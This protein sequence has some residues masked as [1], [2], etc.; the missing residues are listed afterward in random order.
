MITTSPTLYIKGTFNGWGLD[1]PLSEA[2]TGQFSTTICLSSDTH[3]FKITDQDGTALWTFS[4]HPID[5]TL[6]VVNKETPLVNTQG[7][8]NDLHFK[9]Q[10]TGRFDVVVTF[11]GQHATVA[12]SASKENIEPT[13]LRDHLTYQV[14]AVHY[15]PRQPPAPVHNCLA[16]DQLFAQI[17][18]SKSSPFPFV[19]GDNQDG[20]YEGKTHTFANAGKYRHSQGWY[21]GTFASFIDGKINDKTKALD[22]RLQAYG[23]EHRYES[24]TD[25]F[26]LISGQR[27]ACLSVQSHQ[28]KALSIVPELN[29]AFNQSEISTFKHGIVY[30]LPAS[31]CPDGAP[32]HIA[33]TANKPCTFNEVSFSDHPELDSTLHLSGDNVK[34]FI[35]SL[36]NETQFD[37]YLCFAESKS[38]AIH[39]AKQAID[40]DLV[41]LNRY[42]IY[43]F[44]CKN[45]L[46]TNDIEYNRAVMWARL[47]SRTFVNHEFGAGIWAGLPWFK[48]CWGRDTF[49]AL[50]GTSLINGQFSE[51]KEIITNFA[52][53]QMTDEN[54]INYGRVPNRVTSLTNMIYNTTD[55]TPWMIREVMEYLNYSGDLT[56]AQEI[57]PV[58]KRFVEGIEKRYLDENGLM[59]HRDPDTWMDAKIDG[60]IPWSARGNRANDIQALWYASLQ[61]AIVLAELN[62][63]V[64]AKTHWASL[65][66]QVRSNFESLFWNK[67]TQT[68]ADRIEADGQA[69]YSIRPNQLMTLTV[70]LQEPL[71]S[72]EIGSNVVS[73]AVSELLFPWGICSLS[74]SDELFHPYHDKQ[75]QYHKDSA[76][77]NGTIWGWNAGFTV[78]S[79]AM[80]GGENLAYQLSKN[81]GQQIT[82]QGHIGTMSENLD[83]WQ[84]N[85]A[86]LVESGTFAQAW[87]VSEYARNAQQDYLG[88]KPNL[89]NNQLVLHPKLPTAWHEFTS[90]LPFGCGDN[91]NLSFN[92]C[93]DIQ[94]FIFQATQKESMALKLILECQTGSRIEVSGELV[95]T[96]K[97]EFNAQTGELKSDINNLEAKIE[98]SIHSDSVSKLKFT[99]PNWEIEPTSMSQPN[100]L[101]DKIENQAHQVAVD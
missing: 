43:H 36:N 23:L 38:A 101:K 30:S 47:A 71:L 100:F 98:T 88:F 62:Q 7:V 89:L 91:L 74:Q 79:L 40:S 53:M 87:S 44:L 82:D 37:V 27:T 73:N 9:P 25:R 50:S 67:E 65:L 57:Y 24:S 17:E 29:I 97:V 5:T 80:F 3:A 41:N 2:A 1:S 54:S 59:T 4:G 99:Q 84:K 42:S 49:I 70:P 28:P 61:S 46:W 11:T 56:F 14:D 31:L 94:H 63:D 35:H 16:S 68:L 85:D 76:Y 8:G 39:L 48:D 86:D 12:V 72:P 20:Y 34:L 78:S 69:D 52:S 92:R 60:Q 45:Y 95:G 22:A 32:Q 6:L 93:G 75:N 15:L 58:V 13:A 18:I 66:Q 83:A 19:F 81:L 26:T 55:G 64:A 10:Q 33:I 96:I 51:A 90:T 77:H 21:L